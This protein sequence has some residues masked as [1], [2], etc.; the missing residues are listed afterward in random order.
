MEKYY[1]TYTDEEI[2]VDGLNIA[3]ENNYFTIFDKKRINIA[4]Y[5]ILRV[6]KLPFNMENFNKELMQ[7]GTYKVNMVIL[8]EKYDSRIL[9][10]VKEI[11][12]INPETKQIIHNAS[13]NGNIEILDWI[14][15]S[16]YELNCVSNSIHIHIH[17]ACMDGHL[18]VLEW[19]RNNI[20]ND[21]IKMSEY[22]KDSTYTIVSYGHVHILDWM[23]NN[24]IIIIGNISSNSFFDL[25]CRNGYV[26]ILDWMKNNNIEYLPYGSSIGYACKNGHVSILEWFKNNGG[27]NY[28]DECI[29]MA[30]ENEHIEI[31]EWF[32]SNANIEIYYD[33]IKYYKPE[34]KNWLILNGFVRQP[35]KILF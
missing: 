24:N 33:P 11:L 1:I 20:I 27:I 6:V 31:L 8:E 34:I 16:E 2:Y 19:F 28:D 22:L 29:K 30:L 9:N 3:I 26:H 5:D 18:N 12:K 4:N 15:K 35:L 7:D 23:K 32:K 13:K 17:T 14:L 10:D 21:N 25:I